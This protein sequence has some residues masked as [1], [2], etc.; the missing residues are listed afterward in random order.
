MILSGKFIP[1]KF[2]VAK[3]KVRLDQTKERLRMI[4]P[5]SEIAPVRCFLKQSHTAAIKFARQQVR[6]QLDRERRVDSFHSR[7]RLRFSIRTDKISTYTSVEMQWQQTI[8]PNLA[9]AIERYQEH[10]AAR[11]KFER[12]HQHRR[13]V[14][15]QQRINSIEALCTGTRVRTVLLEQHVRRFK[16]LRYRLP[17]SPLIRSEFERLL[18]IDQIAWLNNNVGELIER[19][20]SSMYGTN[21]VAKLDMTTINDDLTYEVAFSPSVDPRVVLTFALTY[22]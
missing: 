3:R 14:A 16:S 5:R 17:T 18:T 6:V 20:R 19:Q 8:R 15:H 21:W 12:W 22:G 11:R 2:R 13:Q 7:R 9:A 10:S 4:V 1:V